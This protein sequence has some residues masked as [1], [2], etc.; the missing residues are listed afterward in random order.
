M[1]EKILRTLDF[2]QLKL[3][4]EK[5]KHVEQCKREWHRRTLRNYPKMIKD[6]PPEELKL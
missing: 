1:N 2:Y 5:G 4:I 3:F 6:G